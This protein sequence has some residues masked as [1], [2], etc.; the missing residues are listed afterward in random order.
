[1]ERSVQPGD[2]IIIYPGPAIR[3]L[4]L[5]VI[6]TI[7]PEGIYISPVFDDTQRRLLRQGYGKWILNDTLVG[8]I[9]FK[10][11]ESIPQ[12]PFTGTL[13]VDIQML[14]DL[15]DETLELVRQ[16]DKEAQDLYQGQELWKQ[17]IDKYINDEDDML[18]HYTKRLVAINWRKLYGQLKRYYDKI[19]G[20]LI[21]RH[22]LGEYSTIHGLF[23]RKKDA[24]N[25]AVNL[26]MEFSR[27]NYGLRKNRQG[28]QM[29][30]VG[31]KLYTKD[32]IFNKLMRTN[33]FVLWYAYVLEARDLE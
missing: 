20:V 25:S 11:K 3:T 17:R 29:V 8:K 26:I 2:Y 27:D 24:A 14:N 22:G 19:W 18:E 6:R 5:N 10:A 21:L 15:D 32:D 4:Q 1:M 13:E 31:D 28:E 7:S 33:E 12:L 16:L 30:P 23:R 9:E